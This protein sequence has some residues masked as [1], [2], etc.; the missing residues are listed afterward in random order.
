MR[1]SCHPLTLTY[2]AVAPGAPHV[3]LVAALTSELDRAVLHI[4][5]L[6]LIGVTTI[7]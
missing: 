2:L 3:D 4:R 6:S 1:E 7:A 5:T